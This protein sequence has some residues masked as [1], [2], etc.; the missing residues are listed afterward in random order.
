MPAL[1]R[2]TNVRPDNTVLVYSLDLKKNKA[3]LWGM[4]LATLP[5]LFIFGW[6]FLTYLQLV[7]PVIL[8]EIFSLPFKAIYFVISLVVLFAV[9][10]L[11]HELVH[12]IFFWIFTHHRPSFGLRGW[13]AFAS[14][15]GWYIP[16]PRYLVI[17]LAP[18]VFLSVLGMLLLAVLPAPAVVLTLF[19]VTLNAASSVGDLWICI[20]LIFQR[21]PIAV[22]DLGDGMSFYALR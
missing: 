20:R 18:L 19:A 6:L 14:A 11:V 21:G 3:V 7:R 16:R 15:P 17:G 12:G 9:L 22:E 4:N 1:F 5:L 13:Y 8:T 10:I 2:T